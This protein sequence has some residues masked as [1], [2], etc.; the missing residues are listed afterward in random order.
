[1]L[2]EVKNHMLKVEDFF[3]NQVQDKFG[4][5]I[6]ETGLQPMANEI[7]ALQSAF[8]EAELEQLNINKILMELRAIV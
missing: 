3:T 2:S 1:M 4:Q 5:S 8:E 7:Q 6:A